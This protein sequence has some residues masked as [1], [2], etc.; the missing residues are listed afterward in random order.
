MKTE[1]KAFKIA[2]IKNLIKTN[3]GLSKDVLN[4]NDLVDDELSMSEN[5][6]IIK[7]KVIYLCEKPNKILWSD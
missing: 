3:Y 6:N 5:W 7:P 1:N 2:G 4:I